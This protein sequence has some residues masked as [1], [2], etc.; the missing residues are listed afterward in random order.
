MAIR[1]GV[2]EQHTFRITSRLGGIASQGYEFNA[3]LEDA[4]GRAF[5]CERRT[6][7][8]G[9]FLR[10]RAK[11]EMWDGCKYVHIDHYK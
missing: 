11:L 5:D 9:I 7:D 10:G 2:G 8:D 3:T 6:K 4:I 1:S